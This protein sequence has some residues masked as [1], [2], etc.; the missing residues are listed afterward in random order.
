ML[1][2]TRPAGTDEQSQIYIGDDICI[3]ILESKGKW[4]RVGVS[5]PKDKQIRRGVKN[6]KKEN[7]FLNNRN[8]D[9]HGNRNR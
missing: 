8:A 7:D 9:R 5:A 4:V 6:D 2:I 3:T 1:V